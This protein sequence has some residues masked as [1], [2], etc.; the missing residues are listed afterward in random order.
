MVEF[1]I[2]IIIKNV[3]FKKKSSNLTI[4]NFIPIYIVFIIRLAVLYI[5]KKFY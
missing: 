5:N 3:V 4:K 1:I 2:L